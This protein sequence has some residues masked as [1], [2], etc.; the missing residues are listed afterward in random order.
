MITTPVTVDVEGR[1]VDASL[2]LGTD[3][4]GDAMVLTW[5]DGVT[6]REVVV[7]GHLQVFAQ[8]FLAGRL[9]R[10]ER[11]CDRATKSL[12]S[13][14]LATDMLSARSE[15]SRLKW[16]AEKIEAFA[17]AILDAQKE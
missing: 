5:F 2:T 4:R 15:G 16:V 1:Q 14:L 3:E 17:H 13:E 8:H 10:M 7:R 9:D 11:C 6:R 12:V